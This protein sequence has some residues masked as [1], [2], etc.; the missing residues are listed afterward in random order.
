MNEVLKRL[1]IFKNLGQN[2][3]ASLAERAIRKRFPK[4][5]I[6]VQE[7]DVGDSLMVILTGRVKVVLN[8]EEGKEIILSILKDGDF[9]GEMSLLDGEP[10]SATVI[11]MEDS[12]FL[13]IQRNDFLYQ[14]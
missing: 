9:F 10:R 7:D 12:T 5:S 2:E 1:P 3:L 13:V 8:S 11:A 6:I 14:I 4:E